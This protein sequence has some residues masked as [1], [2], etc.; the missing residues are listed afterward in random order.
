M[1]QFGMSGFSKNG[2]K[3]SCSKNSFSVA[4]AGPYASTHLLG[5]D[6]LGILSRGLAPKIGSSKG[7]GRALSWSKIE[8]CIFRLSPSFDSLW[9]FDLRGPVGFP[10]G[11]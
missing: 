5:L 10:M 1:L 6:P 4:S 9:V 2:F 3:Y 8:S 11:V 7:A